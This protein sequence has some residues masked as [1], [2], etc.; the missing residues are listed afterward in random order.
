MSYWVD[1][2]DLMAVKPYSDDCLVEVCLIDELHI[3]ESQVARME[4]ERNDMF[5]H[6]ER[7]EKERRIRQEEDLRRVFD[8]PRICVKKKEDIT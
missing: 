5:T 4:R 1:K 6:L 8:R 2:G 7:L 3:L